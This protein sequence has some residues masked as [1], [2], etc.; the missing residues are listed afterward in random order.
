MRAGDRLSLIDRSDRLNKSIFHS[1]LN[2]L[3]DQSKHS[4]DIQAFYYFAP[5]EELI[6]ENSCA[7]SNAMEFCESLESYRRIIA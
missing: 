6:Q 4:I 5:F 2:W 7:I 3:K 1:K